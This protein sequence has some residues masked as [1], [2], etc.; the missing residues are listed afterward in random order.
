MT[1][2]A[3]RRSKRRLCV[4]GFQRHVTIL[5]VSSAADVSLGQNSRKTAGS[6]QEEGVELNIN[7]RFPNVPSLSQ[8]ASL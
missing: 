6:G 5:I 4:E 7:Y 1:G 8:N 3:S 2:R